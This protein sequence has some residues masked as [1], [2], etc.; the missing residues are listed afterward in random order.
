MFYQYTIRKHG[1]VVSK[2]LDMLEHG[3]VQVTKAKLET[4]SV[5]VL[6]STCIVIYIYINNKNH[7]QQ[8]ETK[9]VYFSKTII[10]LYDL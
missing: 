3:S 9:Q 7:N 6:K 10:V 8:G 5:N 1:I 4:L 2:P